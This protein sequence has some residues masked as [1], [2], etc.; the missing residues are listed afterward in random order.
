M[1]VK[2][3][4]WV[5]YLDNTNMIVG[6]QDNSD[7][8]PFNDGEIMEF[9]LAPEKST[10]PRIY[11]QG[12]DI[13]VDNCLQD[14]I[15]IGVDWT[16]LYGKSEDGNMLLFESDVGFIDILFLDKERLWFCHILDDDIPSYT[17]NFTQ[18]NLKEE[19]DIKVL[20]SQIEDRLTN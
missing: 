7:K 1:K 6:V 20:F 5:I 11:E 15:K 14:P 9:T 10:K 18:I 4:D 16:Q 17:G 3:G 8:D 19:E 13:F 12:D 2:I